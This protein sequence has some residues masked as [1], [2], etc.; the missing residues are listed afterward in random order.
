MLSYSVQLRYNCQ[1]ERQTGHKT[2]K[3]K[4]LI[5]LK[6]IKDKT[7]LMEACLT[8][9]SS[10]LSEKVSECHVTAVDPVTTVKISLKY[11]R[12]AVKV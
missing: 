3:V 11:E 2:I 12:E 4:V 7:N 10:Q 9:V 5:F 8:V 6:S 1:N